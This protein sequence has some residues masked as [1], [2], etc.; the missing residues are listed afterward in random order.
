MIKQRARVAET[1][2][3]FLVT[4]AVALGGVVI[5]CAPPEEKNPPGEGPE[6]P[7]ASPSEIKAGD[8]EFPA[9]PEEE[10]DLFAPRKGP[11]E[12]PPK[13]TPL[14]RPITRERIAQADLSLHE[15]MYWDTL[16]EGGV[17]CSLCPT[18]C[19]LR[20]GERGA[21]KVRVNFGDKLYSLVFG[22]AVAVHIDPMEK[23]P[24]YHFL[25]GTPILSI[26]TAGCNLGC[27]FCQNWSISQAFPEDA[28]HTLLEPEAVVALARDRSLGAIAYTYT[29][30]SIFYEYML[31]TARLARRAGI[32]NVYVTCGYLNE[33]PLRELAKVM[34]AANVDL[35]GFS[36]SFYET[37]CG[38]HLA[39]VLDA[40]RILR[41]EGVHVEI[42]NLVIPGAND[43]AEMIREMCRWILREVGPD[44]PLH[45]SRYHPD[46]RM[47][48]P[49]ATP[50]A[51]LTTAAGIAREEGIRHVYIGNLVTENGNNTFCPRCRRLLIR[52]AGF[53]LRENHVR[54]GRCEYCGEPIAGVW[55]PAP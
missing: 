31:E 42:T 7:A 10:K 50:A 17:R 22:R 46:Y 41:E 15:A 53:W 16:P 6:S 19:I 4:A 12:K 52:R 2:L 20:E 34:D 27:R 14:V 40:I 47:E 55:S 37:Y 36:E 30:P 45:F 32:K 1:L 21:C 51:T 28:P 35:K 44:V 33:A 9:P 54:D 24:L 29:E 23:K 13:P 43:S 26:A 48:R 18:R 3:L 8:V 39:P 5:L 25:P 49:S 38:A 11:E